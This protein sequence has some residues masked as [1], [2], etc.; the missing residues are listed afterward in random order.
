MINIKRILP[1]LLIGVIF[2]TKNVYSQKINQFD[3]NGKR[4]GVWKKLYKNG[5][6]RYQ[7]QFKNGKEV[8]VFKFYSITSPSQPV[9]I[10]EFS[11]TSDKALVS[12]YTSLG[13]LKSKGSMIG[14]NR[15]GKWLYYF[16]NGKVISEE[17]YVDGK[18][19]GV[20][21][22][23][24]GNGK[25]TEETYYKQGKKDGVS[26]IYTEDGILIEELNY[27]GGKLNGV[28]KYFDLKGNL[29]EKGMYKDGKRAGEWEFYID[30]VLVTDKEE[31]R[32][33]KKLG[34]FKK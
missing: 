15:V 19:D 12:F 34:R 27:V 33:T 7:G 10:K 24:Y 31:K 23:Y 20:L 2:F 29:K 22:N 4:T 1:L 9:I 13:K 21:K 18:L 30:G 25:T 11:E 5:E 26:K 28:G 17:N 16:P 3:A 14:K 6:I 32:K 8:G